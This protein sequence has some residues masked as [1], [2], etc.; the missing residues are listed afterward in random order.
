MK[1]IKINKKGIIISLV[2][3]VITGCI[4]YKVLG[5]EEE[6]PDEVFE[7]LFLFELYIP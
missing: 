4:G 1:K 3:I 7:K 5:S 2:M 6:I